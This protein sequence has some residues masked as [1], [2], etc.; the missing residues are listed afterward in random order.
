MIIT[1][2]SKKQ[3]DI[4]IKMVIER[5]MELYP[6]QVT[7]KITQTQRE[8]RKKRGLKTSPTITKWQEAINTAFDVP[9]E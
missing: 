2:I 9:F 3:R 5:Y 4:V 6:S 7:H 1:P 8:S